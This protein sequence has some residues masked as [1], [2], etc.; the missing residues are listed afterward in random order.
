MNRNQGPNGGAPEAAGTASLKRLS[1]GDW[2]SFGADE[3]AYIRPVVVNGVKAIA[4]HAADGTPI[5]AAPTPELAMAAV[6][7]HEMEPVLVH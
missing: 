5:G 2:A 4:I 6:R 1:I 7:Q 3:I